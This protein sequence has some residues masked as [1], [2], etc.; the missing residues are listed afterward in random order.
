MTPS[1]CMQVPNIKFNVAKMLE[2]LAPLVEPVVVERTI[3]PCLLELNSD[4]DSD[5]R[6]FASQALAHTTPMI[7]A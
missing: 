4:G 3:R 1:S 5:V 6:F 7:S 2:R